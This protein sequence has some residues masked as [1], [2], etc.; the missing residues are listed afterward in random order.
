MG[1]A[2]AIPFETPETVEEADTGAAVKATTATAILTS[3]GV[4][5]RV[6]LQWNPSVETVLPF[7]IAAGFYGGARHGFASGA[8][9]FFVTNFL[10]WGGQG[11]WTV[12]QCLGAG[13]GAASA[14]YFAKASTSGKSFTAAL[15]VG[16][17]IF[18]IAVNS[19]SL[20][21]MPFGLASLA[22]ALPF[23]AVHLASSLSFGAI[24]YGNQRILSKVYN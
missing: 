15:I 6:A 4:V 14:A 9:G 20:L 11:P 2:T 19:G 7:A 16:T 24:I 21:Y 3:L 10:I 22:A 1:S 8:S 12:F 23:A 18:E 5:G 13:L 17:V